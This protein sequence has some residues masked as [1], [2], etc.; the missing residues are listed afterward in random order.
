M[1]RQIASMLLTRQLDWLW[2]DVGL[3]TKISV[4]VVAGTLSLIGLFAYWGAVALHESR[5]LALQDRLVLAQATAG[6]VD[7]ALAYVE[8]VLRDAATR[9]VWS[10]PEQI[11]LALERTLER[12]QLHAT[13]I[14]LT[15]HTGHVIAA[16]PAITSAVDLSHFAAVS[17]VLL[18]E[19]FAVSHDQRAP[20]ADSSAVAATPVRNSSNDANRALVIGINLVNSPYLALFR[21]MNLGI[22]GYV[23]LIDPGARILAS[24]CP[25][26][27]GL[28]SHPTDD[29]S[30]MILKH[31]PVVST[32]HECF[33]SPSAPSSCR[34]V[35]AFAP[36][37]YAPWGVAVRQRQDQVLA[38]MSTFQIH[39]LMLMVVGVVG[40]LIIVDLITRTISRPVQALD[41]VT[42]RIAAGDLDSPVHVSKKDE[43]GRLARSLDL[44]RVRLKESIHHLNLQVRDARAETRT[45]LKQNAMLY[46]ELQEK[47]Q[48]RR[49]LLGRVFSAQEE[50]R[51]RISR[52]LHDETCQ[53]LNS[54][55]YDLDNLSEMLAQS[56]APP[57]EISPFLQKMRSLAKTGRD[58]VGRII[59]DLRPTMLDHLG[60]VPALRWYAGIRLNDAGIHS[61][62]REVGRS[63]RFLPSIETALFRTVQEAVNNIAQHSHA[64]QA[65]F[66]FHYADERVDVDITD[67]GLGFDR[68]ATG[69][70]T[71]G[72]RGLGLIGMEERM[73]SVGGQFRLQTAP[74]KGT[75]VRLAVPLTDQAPSSGAEGAMNEQDPCAGRG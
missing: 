44:M 11:D 22:G 67:D 70:M 69:N 38:G 66:V 20:T 43:I 39:I 62:F 9:E 65:D 59:F 19:S 52:E 36:L 41:T 45:A 16:R 53:I 4:L 34:E 47:E 31:D 55:A 26:R 13:H 57:S 17:N 12:L 18:G 29:L 56:A 3:R 28:T 23:D 74:G 27:V 33:A 2:P 49:K 50:E 60:L 61:S 25:A 24:T 51:K 10:D 7:A 15:D 40:D 21:S 14:F 37:E 64:R 5:E 6:Q 32:G 72:G 35:L 71:E 63:P 75:I 8:H 73:A 46:A 42:R 1:L 30:G 58:G 68:A 54:L 48:M